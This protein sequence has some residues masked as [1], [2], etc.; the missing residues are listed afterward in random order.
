[1]NNLNPTFSQYSNIYDLINGS[2][3]YKAEAEKIVRLISQYSKNEN[4]YPDML[5]IGSGTGGHAKYFSE[6]FELICLEKSPEMAEICAKKTGLHVVQGEA[7]SFEIEKR[8]DAITAMFHVINY[9]Q[10]LNELDQFLYN[11]SRHLKQDGVLVFDMWHLPSVYSIGTSSRKV[12]VENDEFDITR[13]SIPE[14]DCINNIVKVLFNFSVSKKNTDELYEFSETHFMRPW[15]ISEIKF[16]AAKNGLSIMNDLENSPLAR[17]PA[18]SWDL[19]I[20]L[21]HSK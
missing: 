3:N 15:T 1:M 13:V 17:D 21:G 11:S 6:Y 16:F 10:D 8:F 19:T 12:S 2:K 18:Y 4:S 20:V 14:H 5:E 9:L 7:Q